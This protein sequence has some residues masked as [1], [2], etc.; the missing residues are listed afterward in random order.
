M[1]GAANP[2]YSALGH[3]CLLGM[4]RKKDEDGRNQCSKQKNVRESKLQVTEAPSSKDREGMVVNSPLVKMVSNKALQE[5]TFN[6]LKQEVEHSF[7]NYK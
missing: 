1:L 3:P 6:L 7:L 4:L 5:V 2:N